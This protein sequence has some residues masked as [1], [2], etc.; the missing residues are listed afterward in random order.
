MVS[1]VGLMY[2]TFQIQFDK[3]KKK[4][5]KKTNEGLK[6][7]TKSKR[8]RVIICLLINKFSKR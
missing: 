2:N 8:V 6:D 3:K 5:Y 7:P 4:V 1:H